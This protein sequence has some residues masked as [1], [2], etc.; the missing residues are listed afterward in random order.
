MFTS[1]GSQ[2]VQMIVATHSEYVLQSALNDR[3]DVLVIVLTDDNGTVSSKKITAPNVLPTIT[4]AETNYLAFGVPSTDYHI[5][6]YA[7]LQTKTGKH[8]ISACD[9]YIAQQPQY[10]D[11]KHEK[12]DN[13][14]PG[15]NYQTLPTY[16]RN[17]I[18]HPD[19][20]RPYTDEELRTSIE[21]LIKLCR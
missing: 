8:S 12:I 18:D 7:Y 16:I 9:Q 17:A 5:A 2:T 6:L 3:D 21:L 11:S 13:S 10:D 19:N 20:P 1:N 15:H 14:Y 4:A